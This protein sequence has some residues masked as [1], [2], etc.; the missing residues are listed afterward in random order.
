V[1]PRALR[2][3]QSIVLLSLVLLGLAA[4]TSVAFVGDTWLNLVLG[5]DIVSKGLIVRND[6]TQQGFG[7]PCVD[8]QWLSHLVY[9]EL[10]SHVGLAST[11]V[12]AAVLTAG[13][14]LA[15][16]RAAL[17]DGATP[18]RTLLI[19]AVAYIAVLSQAVVRAQTLVLPFF[20][21]FPVLLSRDAR[22]PDRRTWLLVPCAALWA[23]LHGSVLLA[24]VMAAVLAATRVVDRLRRREG[25]DA[26]TIARDALLVAALAAAVLASPYGM[27]LP[28]Y[29]ASTFGNPAFRAHV[30]EWEPPRLQD[31]AAWLLV[32][33]T[34]AILLRTLKTIRTFDVCLMAIFAIGTVSAVRYA[35]PFAFTVAALLPRCADDALGQRLVFDSNVLF[36]RAARVFLAIALP[37]FAAIP[38]LASFTIRASFSADVTDAVAAAVPDKGLVLAD[39]AQG[40]RLLWFHPELRGRVSHDSR[41]ETIPRD[42]LKDLS[43]LYGEPTAPA[44]RALLAGYDTVLVDRDKHETLFDFLAHDPGWTDVAR[45]KYA[46]AFVRAQPGARRD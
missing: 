14:F 6:L 39:E 37:A 22:K 45:D 12:L 30:S 36:G 15:A 3:P 11:V 5:R 29:Y 9:Y 34:A 17:A 24:P 20:V 1:L 46:H 27:R 43:L 26:R 13:A 28:S 2:L 31:F 33:A 40:D 16:V 38:W 44:A 42:F 7:A 4:R 8:L 19:G 35:T 10:G 25:L 18:G 32:A 23:N 21:V 41:I